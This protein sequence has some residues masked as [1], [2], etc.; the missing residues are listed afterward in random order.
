MLIRT[1]APEE[2]VQYDSV[3]SHPVQS[4]QWGEFKKQSGLKVERIGF[5]EHDTLMRAMQ[6]TFHPVPLLGSVGYAAKV[7]APDGEQFDALR[8]AARKHGALFTKIEPD[9]FVPVDVPDPAAEQLDAFIR[10]H[11]GISG[12][13][14]YT[15]HNFHLDL[16]PDNDMLFAAF[17]TK[18]RYN[19]RLAMKKGVEIVEESSEAGMETYIRLMIETT[20]RQKFYSHSPEFFRTLWR[21]IG[22]DE[23]SMLRI[24]YARYHGEVLV[25]W[26]VFVFNKRLYYPYGASSNQHRE[27]MASNLMMWHIIQ[28]GKAQGC[29]DLDMWG[30]LG[31]NADPNDPFYGFHRF[32]QGY[33]PILMKNLGAYDLV[34]KNISYRIFERLNALRWRYLRFRRR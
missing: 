6:V 21:V 30:A 18:T 16:R 26:L 10:G 3:V 34:H 22:R 1:I 14:I 17:A 4:W 24:F 11:G 31:P 33:N 25:A 27:L 28:Y 8:Q 2:R 9:V 13:L 20:Q 15:Q 23:H 19:T 29:V 7:F 32:K 5:F 12:E